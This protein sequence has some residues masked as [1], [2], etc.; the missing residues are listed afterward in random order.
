MERLNADALDIYDWTDFEFYDLVWYWHEGD[1][2]QIPNISRW[3]EA[4]H[5]CGS[6]LNYF[7]LTDIERKITRTT[8]QHSTEKEVQK[9]EVQ[10]LIRYYSSG[11]HAAIG[12]EVVVDLENDS[13]FVYNADPRDPMKSD[14]GAYYGVEKDVDVDVDVDCTMKETEADMY[15]KY[16]GTELHLPDKY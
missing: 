11:M 16:I 4:V 9:Q 8:V 12:A 13:I 10:Q 5:A 14:D 2:K 15:Y 6:A 1:E 7:I 3:I